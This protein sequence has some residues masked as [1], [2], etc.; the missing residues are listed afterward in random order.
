[1][2]LRR[3]E[4]PREHHGT[5]EEAEEEENPKIGFQTFISGVSPVSLLHTKFLES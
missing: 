1:M 5:A 3:R 4:V 2:P